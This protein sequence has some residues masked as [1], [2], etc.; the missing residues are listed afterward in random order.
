MQYVHILR[1]FKEKE[2]CI[3]MLCKGVLCVGFI[4][5]ICGCSE[6]ATHKQVYIVVLCT[7]R[8]K[9]EK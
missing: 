8:I 4:I 3:I 5:L 9:G 1:N 7:V 2:T 6:V